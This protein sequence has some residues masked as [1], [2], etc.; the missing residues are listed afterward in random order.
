MAPTAL[1]LAVYTPDLCSR[2]NQAV[3]P[4]VWLHGLMVENPVRAKPLV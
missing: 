4:E 3:Q 1:N 2:T